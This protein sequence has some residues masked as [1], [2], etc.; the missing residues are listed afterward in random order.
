MK[1]QRRE[2]E[3]KKQIRLKLLKARG[4]Q[5]WQEEL[6]EAPR[7]V[8]RLVGEAAHLHYLAKSEKYMR[9]K[10]AAKLIEAAP[11]ELVSEIQLKYKKRTSMSN[12]SEGF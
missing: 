8:M 4:S 11:N 10:C 9:K 7:D 2:L 12:D 3:D 6:I 1:R 5:R